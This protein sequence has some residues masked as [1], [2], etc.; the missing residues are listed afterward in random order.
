MTDDTNAV[1]GSLP[2]IRIR[3]SHD[4]LAK[5]GWRFDTAVEIIYGPETNHDDALETLDRLAMKAG[6]LGSLERR[7]RN[8]EDGYAG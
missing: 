4:R 8:D 7:R 6:M 3:V 2:Q 5:E 1:R